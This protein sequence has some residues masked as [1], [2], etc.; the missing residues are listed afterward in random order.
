MK[1]RMHP[2]IIL[3]NVLSSLFV[4]I[5]LVIYFVK[6]Q[7][8]NF[9]LDAI[10]ETTNEVLG[11]GVTYLGIILITFFGLLLVFIVGFYISWRNTYLTFEKDHIV[12]EK[13]KLF[14]KVTTIN[15]SDI[16]TINLKRN[17][18]EKLLNTA[19]IKFELNI[20]GEETFKSKIVFNYQDA[21]NIK[22]K[23]LNKEE[24]E[25][26][27]ESV[28]KVTSADII[29]HM[30]LSVNIALIIFMVFIYILLDIFYFDTTTFQGTIMM[31]LMMIILFGP[32]VISLI[33]NF[34]S[35]Y[36]FKVNRQDNYIKLSYGALTTY[37][38]NI[39]IN[40]INAIIVKRSLQARI[41]GYYLIEV[42]NAGIGN[43]ND[44]EKTILS[45]Y[46]KPKEIAL[47]F[48]YIIPEFQNE[49]ILEKQDN[50]S[51]KAYM[52]GKVFWI[53][54]IV[55]ISF[56]THFYWLLLILLLILISLLEKWAYSLGY[57]NNNVVLK[58]QLIN[59][60]N[61]IIPY[62]KIELLRVENGPFDR[63]FKL[64]RLS[65]NIIGNAS[66][67]TFNTGLFDY[68]KLTKIIQNYE[69]KEEIL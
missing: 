44:N 57:D 8:Q 62:C 14:K 25:E 67:S 18:L 32:I 41:F 45:I 34:L 36:N 26:E 47:I 33:K 46:L 39:D 17:I 23:I 38:Y 55:I 10:T 58:S 60:K 63:L 68:D 52:M 28:I 48:K 56:M 6:E 66:N 7:I 64:Q 51:L 21:I 1:T 4:I 54:L 12:L 53:I 30:F 65:I 43:D 59:K 49:V 37:K 22:N 11:F 20:A 24:T 27:F 50:K 9:D 31:I 61:I 13:G 40:K 2:S 69:E 42:I 29:K 19:N 5:L 3:E 35:Y 16:A 15:I